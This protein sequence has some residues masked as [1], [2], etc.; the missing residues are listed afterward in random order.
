[1]PYIWAGQTRAD[2]GGVGHKTLLN[3]SPGDDALNSHLGWRERVHVLPGDEQV[4]PSVL[5]ARFGRDTNGTS[6]G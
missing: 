4:S 2:F 6:P 3:L 5:Q 1:M